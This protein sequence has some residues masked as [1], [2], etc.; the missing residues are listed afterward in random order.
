MNRISSTIDSVA[1]Q[2]YYHKRK[3]MDALI[4]N[5]NDGRML[6][7]LS[8][9]YYRQRIFKLFKAAVKIKDPETPEIKKENA[10]PD[11]SII[12]SKRQAVDKP[13]VE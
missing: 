13:P 1:D 6:R 2:Q 3:G 12:N 4:M 8:M 5:T 7:S 10:S 11:P 9:L